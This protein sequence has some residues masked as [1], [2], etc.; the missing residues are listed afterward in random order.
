MRTGNS[1]NLKIKSNL[2]TRT[3]SVVLRHLKPIHK[4]ERQSFKVFYSYYSILVKTEA[5][6]GFR[7]KLV[8]ASGKKPKFANS[9]NIIKLFIELKHF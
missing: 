7:N 5:Q 9:N 3:G 1:E 8:L 2:S 6:S 4:K